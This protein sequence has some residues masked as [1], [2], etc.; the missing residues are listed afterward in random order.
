MANTE[1]EQKSLGRTPTLY[2]SPD[3]VLAAM[4]WIADVLLCVNL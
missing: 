2:S 4:I 3:N 1:T